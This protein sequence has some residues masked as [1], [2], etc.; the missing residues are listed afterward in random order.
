MENK[1]LIKSKKFR[2]FIL[3]NFR[4]FL[5]WTNLLDLLGFLGFVQSYNNLKKLLE[6]KQILIKLFQIDWL[7]Y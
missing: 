4:F 6:Q 5:G 7:T 1:Y 2:V 3:L